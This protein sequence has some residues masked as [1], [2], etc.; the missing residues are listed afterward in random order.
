MADAADRARPEAPPPA[1]D[2]GRVVG[3]TVIVVV[4]GALGFVGLFARPSYEM[5]LAAGLL[6][7]S[8]A[9][10]VTA[11]E[12]SR[13]PL[14]PLGMMARGVENGLLFIAFAYAVG[15]AHGLRA[16]FC[17]LS[18]GTVLF[19]MGPTIGCVLAGV[20]GAVASEI[21]RT[22][23][24]RRLVAV[25]AALAG[26]LGTVAMQLGLFYATPIIFAYDPFVGYFSGALYD[27]VL[28]DDGLGSYRLASAATLF[29]V[30]VASL[31][32]ERG[33]G[34]RLRPRSLGRPGLLLLGAA[35]GIGSLLS[36]AYGHDL[37]HWQTPGT[38][39]EALGGERRHGRCRVV[40]DARLPLD[41]VDRLAR[42]CDAHM[43][44]IDDWLGTPAERRLAEVTAF[45]FHD[46]GQKRW[47]MGAGQTSIAKPWRAEIY[48]QNEAYPH[49][50]VGHELV[51][52]LA[53][54]LGRG[55][56][57]I[58]GELGGLLPNP[59]LIEGIAV[60][61]SPR[62][63]NL[64]ADEWSAAM[65]R[66]GVLPPVRSLFGL[67][68]LG[69]ASSTSYTAAGSFVGF[70]RR[71]HG[72]E[73]VRR[74]YGGEPLEA[75]VGRDWAA[76]ET[77]WHAELDAVELRDAALAEAEARFDRP[78]VFGRRCPH[79]VD[80][81][82]GIASGELAAGDYADALEGLSKV[83]RLDPGNWHA[84]LTLATCHDRRGD[85]ASRHA[86]LTELA[87]DERMTRAVRHRAV[88]ALGDLALRAG[89]VAEARARYRT[90]LE[91]ET[92]EGRLRTLD[93]KAHY[94][95]DPVPREAFVALLVGVDHRGPYAQ[96]ALDR[97][98]L[99]RSARPDDG[100]PDYLFARQHVAHSR[101]DLADTRIRAA[102]DRELP[103]DRV[104][105]ESL[106]M[107]VVISCARGDGAAAEQALERY[108]AHPLVTPSRAAYYERLV[109]RCSR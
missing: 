29:A 33:E 51:H 95:A 96:G 15:L 34:G 78:S 75:L 89:D 109:A 28:A 3:A 26:P 80:E 86:V 8:V 10:V 46:A 70:V 32:L 49:P 104:V 73:A 82:M 57:A 90:V 60:A 4:L 63:D 62:D 21:A 97:I 105:S 106:R 71:V 14:H 59:G 83:L 87:G 11:L 35:A 18:R 54:V 93:L 48:L 31:H 22:R 50:V 40:H 84:Q 88:E 68:F 91:T 37:G 64:D 23:S 38:I 25:L 24:R 7:P 45:L 74:W 17:D 47:Y 27:T 1:V 52:A 36:V 76:L 55:P 19:L 108:Q 42:D 107:L 9:A 39:A 94:A 30:Y 92:D 56:F 12:L 6:C 61:G 66:I 98:G 79:V 103:V 72:A 16:G 13:R 85:A 58:A 5:A 65:K 101:Y 2:R 53:G 41:H 102:L 100:T 44:A 67:G 77:A 69:N 20:W 81:T 99:W 43:D